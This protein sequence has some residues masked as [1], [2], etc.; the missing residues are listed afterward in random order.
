MGIDVGSEI[1]DFFGA[2]ESGGDS[3]SVEMV[4]AI[5]TTTKHVTTS[6]AIHIW[7]DPLIARSDGQGS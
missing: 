4:Y 6:N 2:G 3:L 5:I 7:F 1:V